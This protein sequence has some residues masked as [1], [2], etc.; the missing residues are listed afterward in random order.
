MHDRAVKKKKVAERR[1]KKSSNC[2]SYVSKQSD[3]RMDVVEDEGRIC[4]MDLQKE[5]NKQ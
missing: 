5:K 4:M 1:G 2:F 3:F